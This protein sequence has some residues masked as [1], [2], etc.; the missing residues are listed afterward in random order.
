[1][2]IVSF[3]AGCYKNSMNTSSDTLSR[4]ERQIM[5]VVYR[6]G[7]ATVA[8]VT[9]ALP[10]PPSYNTVRTLMGTLERKGQLDHDSD[11]PRYVY[12]ATTPVEQASQ[13]AL[14]RVVQ[15]FFG[16]SA[17]RAAAALLQ[18]EEVPSEA[19]LQAI[20]A[21]IARARDSR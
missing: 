5:D 1:M 2:G 17:T 10:D 7:R 9:A 16:G 4:R 18:R 12:F 8:D 21:L 11:G 15:S 19:E 14:D 20:E 13:S 6:L 3:L